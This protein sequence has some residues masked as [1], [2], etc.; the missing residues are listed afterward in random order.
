MFKIVGSSS[1]ATASA[2]PALILA[3]MSRQLLHLLLS[4]SSAS[5]DGPGLALASGSSSE[6]DS[7][8]AGLASISISARTGREAAAEELVATG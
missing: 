3:I 1:W 4:S 5:L 7:I 2:K 8:P 6:S